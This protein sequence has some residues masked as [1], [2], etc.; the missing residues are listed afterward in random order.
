MPP[1]PIQRFSQY[2]DEAFIRKSAE[3]GHHRAVIGGAWEELGSLQLEFLKS[4]GLL[5]EH[6]L[7]DIG[8]GSFR[9]GVKIIPYLNSGHYF[10]TDA[11]LALLEAGYREEIVKAGLASR[12]PSWNYV[13]NRDFSL[14]NFG[15]I[16]N[17]GIAQ[18]VFTHMP[19]SRLADCL[20][21]IAP[22][23]LVGGVFFVTV[24]LVSEADEEKSV[25]QAAGGIIT[26]AFRDPFH[27]TPTAL[28]LVTAQAP[29]WRCVIIGDWGHP[30]NQ[31]MASFVRTC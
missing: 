4:Q 12:F 30:R 23:F 11:S 3:S 26:S 5:P 15:Q 9:A 24:F 16:F 20:N 13:V 7:I 17:F 1:P 14:A 22:C 8:A 31:K 25:Q 21:A 19:I 6:R 18:S 2:D 27:T 29:G 28:H 10:A